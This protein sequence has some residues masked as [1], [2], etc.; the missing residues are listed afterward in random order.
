MTH[1]EINF[2]PFATNVID[3]IERDDLITPDGK[4]VQIKQ[5]GL[6]FVITIGTVISDILDNLSASYLLNTNQVGY[7]DNMPDAV[8]AIFHGERISHYHNYQK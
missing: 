3:C 7:D 8:I 6:G 4:S 5:S 2:S 1:I